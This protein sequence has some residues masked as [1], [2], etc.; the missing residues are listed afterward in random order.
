[1]TYDRGLEM[2]EYKALTEQTGVKVYFASPYSPC[3]RGTEEQ[4]RIQMDS[5][6]N[7]FLKGLTLQW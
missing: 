2:A 1:M 6:D 5:L 4:M 7:I 3:Q